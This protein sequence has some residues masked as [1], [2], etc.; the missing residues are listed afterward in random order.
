ML[1][2]RIDIRNLGDFKAVIN[3]DKLGAGTYLIK[4]ELEH[5]FLIEHK[6]VLK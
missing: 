2:N 6:V 4:I 5:G 3:S 1:G